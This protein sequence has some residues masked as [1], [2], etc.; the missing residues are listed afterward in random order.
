MTGN[1]TVVGANADDGGDDSGEDDG[2][3]DGGMTGDNVLSV[4]DSDVDAG[5]ATTIDIAL[6]NPSDIIAGF[7]IYLTDF[8]N[9][10]GSFISV[11]GTERT[12]GFTISASE[13]ADGTYIIVGFDLSLTGIQL[14]E[15]PI[16]TVGYQSDGIYTAEIDI[17]ITEES[18][19]S[20]GEG[21]ALGHSATSGTVN[22][23]GEDPPPVFAPE[24]LEAVGGLTMVTL[25]WTHPEPWSVS[26]Y[27]VY[28]DGSLVGST[29]STNYA[30]TGLSNVAAT[31]CYTVTAVSIEQ[32][33]STLSNESCA[34]TSDVYLEE[35][36]NLTAQENG[37]EIYL[38]WAPPGV[39][40]YS[41]FVG[42][43]SWESEV[44]W[45]LHY[46]N[47][48]VATGAVGTFDLLLA[49]GDYIMYMYDSFGDG[50]NGNIFEITNSEGNVVASGTLDTGTE[51]MQEFTLGG[52]RDLLG[53]EVFR[54]N[55][56]LDLTT[57]TNYLDTADLEYLTEY[58]YNVTAVY[59]E[60]NSAFSNEACDSPQ[61]NGPTDLSADGTGSFITIEWNAPG[62][63][64]GF[65]IYRDG[66]QHAYTTDTIF[67]DHDT[68]VV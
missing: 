52:G 7:Q 39:G 66:E 59:D 22:V 28:R 6:D 13:Q 19:L 35:P 18:I 40:E 26:S 65:N 24:D 23:S 11:S 47:E 8:P 38:N 64:D 61:L 57:A 36:S 58:C 55:Q 3:D 4:I 2:G 30:D 45:D 53:Y 33:E 21:L 67:E 20:N 5:Q 16:L 14:G 34:T 31:Y 68:E 1:I 50:W 54:D 12:S 43:G 15:G 63:Q 42:G 46:D 51:G 62:D 48:S 56:V 27:N 25:S 44:T 49:P 41:M 9:T 37:L 29:A 32:V 60:G 10:F 17:S